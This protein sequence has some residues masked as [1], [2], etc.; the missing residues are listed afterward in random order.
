MLGRKQSIANSDW[1]KALE[2]IK[3]T[4]PE[5]DINALTK[6][7][8]AEIKAFTKG[9]KAAYAW[10]GGKDSIVLG[11]L[12]K[13][14]KIEDCMIG[15]CDLEYPAFLK[16]INEN[17]PDKCEI[18]NTGINLDWLA[19]HPDMLFPQKNSLAAR[20]FDIVQHKAQRQY[21]KANELDVMLLGRRRADGNHVGRG[22]NYY[23]DAKGYTFYSP[24]ADWRHED[25]LAFIIYKGLP[26]PPIYD[27]K[28]G[29]LC[30]THPWPARQYTQ[31]IENG[32]QEVYDID[33]SI[34]EG[35][36]E[37]IESARL[38]LEGGGENK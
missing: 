19:K 27:W 38:F 14:A 34:V 24:L 15:I 9:K 5:K 36:A 21:Y 23:T 35:A 29:Y 17:K 28:N 16:W 22:N 37:K 7:T 13:Q 1:I 3:E 6:R 20:W 18:I 33:R 10:S 4:V 8:V 31:S 2:T 30:G 26:L 11:A 32:W 25:I 12:C